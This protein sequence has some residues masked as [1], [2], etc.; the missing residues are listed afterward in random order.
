MAEKIPNFREII[1]FRNIL[2]HGYAVID[3][4]RVW[5]VV[6]DDLPGLRAALNAL[7]GEE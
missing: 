6:K 3:Y 7:L 1:A 4:A 2:A 5:R